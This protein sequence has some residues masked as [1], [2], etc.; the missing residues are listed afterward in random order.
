MAGKDCMEVTKEIL[1][2]NPDQRIIF[3]SAYVKETL[4]NS[5]KEFKRVVELLQKPFEI[6]AFI[7][8][9]EDKQSL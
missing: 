2:I 5:V 4:E 1:T 8:T 7:D 3:A 6:H 9:I